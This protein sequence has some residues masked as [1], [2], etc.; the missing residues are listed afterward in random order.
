M[1]DRLADVRAKLGG[2]GA[3]DRAAEAV[4][5]VIHSSHAP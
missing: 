2:P 4:L 3:S 5:D 1:I